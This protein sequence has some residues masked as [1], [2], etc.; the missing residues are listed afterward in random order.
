MLKPVCRN[1]EASA[2]E[3]SEHF[4]VDHIEPMMKMVVDTYN[5]PQFFHSLAKAIAAE[6]AR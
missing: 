4:A 2:K 6:S 5:I 1:K 3:V